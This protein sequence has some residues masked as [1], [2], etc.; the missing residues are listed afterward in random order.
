MTLQPEP[1]QSWSE[2][3]GSDSGLVLPGGPSQ[4]PP[5]AR[6][7]RR[8]VSQLAFGVLLTA[9]LAGLALSAVGVAH[10]LLPRQ[11]TVAQRRAISAWEMER[12]WRALP[13]GTIFPAS[14][15][16]ELPAGT[17]YATSSLVL[18]ARRLGM[19][20]ATSCTSAVSGTAIRILSE[21]G[22]SA[23]MRATYADSSGSLVATLTVAVLP[24][25]SATRTVVRDLPGWGAGRP[26]VR[27]MRIAGT[28]AAGFGDGERQI[29]GTAGVGPYVILVTAGFADGR[30]HVRLGH[31]YLGEEMAALTSGLVHAASS[32]LGGPVAVPS[33]PGAPGC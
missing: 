14:P 33:C 23:A 28:P 21:N 25:A 30:H 26:V 31:T 27:T 17:L 16:Y 20:P 8:R 32:V 15:P 9:G 18:N 29:S 22:C 11:F 6:R 19:S 2:G 7:L 1:D 5:L 24:S 10:Q 12:R 4:G 3:P 13:A